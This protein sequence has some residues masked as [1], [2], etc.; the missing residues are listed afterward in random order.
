[1]KITNVRLREVVGVLQHEG[2]FWEERL[3]RPIDVYPEHRA[4]GAGGWLP[5]RIDENYLRIQT[6]LWRSKP[7]KASPASAVRSST[8]PPTRSTAPSVIS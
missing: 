7:T 6:V 4:E 1:M 5:T 3:I 2:E 8:K